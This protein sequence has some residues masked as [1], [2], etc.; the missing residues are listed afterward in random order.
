[1]P[2]LKE[3]T[4]AHVDLWTCVRTGHRLAAKD[5]EADR[6][7]AAVAI[8][9]KLSLATEDS[10]FDDAPNLQLADPNSE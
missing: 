6:W 8:A 7:V 9:A 4:D 3:V 5:H 10:I 2:P 1:M